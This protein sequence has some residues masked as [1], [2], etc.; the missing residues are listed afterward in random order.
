M[1]CWWP[2]VINQVEKLQFMIFWILTII[3][4]ICSAFVIVLVRKHIVTKAAN[5]ALYLNL[6]NILLF[7]LILI[8]LIIAIQIFPVGHYEILSIFVVY[9]LFGGAVLLHNLVHIAIVTCNARKM[10]IT[11]ILYKLMNSDDYS[12][13]QIA[14]FS[15]L[16]EYIYNSKDYEALEFV[17]GLFEKRLLQYEEGTDD[18][19]LNVIYKCLNVAMYGPVAL[20]DNYHI[21]SP[22]DINQNLMAQI[23]KSLLQN[24]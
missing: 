1:R 17:Y 8:G 9:S 6:S 4:L 18:N 14:T 24:N 5:V 13:T 19:T 21:S 7:F 11:S 23:H 22:K 20:V 12:E 3:N 15:I 10:N 2:A 16:G